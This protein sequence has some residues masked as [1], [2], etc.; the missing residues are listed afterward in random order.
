MHAWNKPGQ[1]GPSASVEA[2]A[3]ERCESRLAE[4]ECEL[5]MERLRRE[6]RERA[7]ET[8]EQREARETKE[9][10][11][12]ERSARAEAASTWRQEEIQRRQARSEWWRRFFAA[13][14]RAR[15][16]RRNSL[17]G[18]SGTLRVLMALGIPATLALVLYALSGE[19]EPPSG[20]PPSAGTETWEIIGLGLL[21]ATASFA[22][23]ALLGFL[24]GIPRSSGQQAK[25]D[26]AE[27]EKNVTA[28]EAPADPAQ[29]FIANTNLEQISDWLTKILVGVGLIQIHEVGGAIEDLANGLA[30]G[31]G[32]QGFAVAVT[33]LVAFSITGFVGAYLY[34]RLRLQTAFE[35]ALGLKKV[36]E[37]VRAET[38]ALT[39]VQEQLNPGGENR[40]TLAALTEALKAATEG[41]RKQA[42][43]LARRQRH[44]KLSEDANR[45]EEK[46]FGALSIPVLEALIGCETEKRYPRLRAE[47]GYTLLAQ[48]D[49][50][51]ARA[52]FDEAIALRDPQEAFD[53]PHYELNRALC[54][55]E[56]S[57]EMDVASDLAIDAVCDDLETGMAAGARFPTQKRELIAQ[58]LEQKS[59][60]ATTPAQTRAADLLPAVTKIPGPAD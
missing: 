37:E 24:F 55:V 32:S 56:L 33:L 42:F 23:G 48:K 21:V 34:T 59:R 12:Q 38:A 60:K 46:E 41:V 31:L 57:K 36:R 52:A 45:R 40:P 22:V 43:F 27:G 47:L 7:E 2:Q 26:A 15:Q 8:P 49:F 28:E 30:P 51:A 6:E 11:R 13:I 4:L 17:Q 29:R 5:E 53:T 16:R 1:G 19:T 3:A 35:Q 10:D 44:E 9:L 39:L 20:A 50:A 25:G 58:W 18:Q 54:T 14:G